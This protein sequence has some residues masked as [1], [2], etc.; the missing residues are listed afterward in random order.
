MLAGHGSLV[1]VSGEAGIG[2]TT[3]FEW[4]A[5]E[6]EAEGC[7]VLKG[8]CY[9]LTTTPPYGPWRELSRSQPSSGVETLIPSFDADRTTPDAL[10]NRQEL[11]DLMLTS[12]AGIA[13]EQPLT[14]ILEDLHWSDAA[15]LDLLRVVARRLKDLS[16]LLVATYRSDELTRRHPMYQILPMLIRESSSRRI[17]LRPLS[18]AATSSMIAR[19][20]CARSWEPHSVSRLVVFAGRGQ[21]LLPRRA[22]ARVGEPPAPSGT[23]WL[24]DP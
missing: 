9:D 1:L 11:V 2:K 19:R 5:R 12:L 18:A 3:L 4:L 10:A 6:A 16:I 21:P 20:Y 23:G 14:I 24:M 7:L 8:G 15:S 13:A 22:S 17:E